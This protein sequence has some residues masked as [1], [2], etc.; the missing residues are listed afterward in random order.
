MSFRL[1]VLS[2]L[3][4]V[5][6]FV[7]CLSSAHVVSMSVPELAAASPDIVVATVEGKQSRWNSQHTL[8][9]TDYTL[10]VEDRL[11]GEAPD[12]ISITV[13]GGTVGRIGDDLCVSVHLEPGARYLLFLG[14]IGRLSLTPVVGAGQGMF[15]E[16]SGGFA[17]R[18]EGSDPVLLKGRPVHFRDLVS[19]MRA[20]V[21]STPLAPRSAGKAD[22]R[23]PAKIWDPSPGRITGSAPP[24]AAPETMAI[25]ALPAD[26]PPIVE[27]VGGAPAS[28]PR[29]PMSKFVYEELA[30][31]PIVVNPLP[32][33]SPFSP[34]DQYAMS[35]WNRYAG[36]MFQVPFSPSPF[37]SYGNGVF[38]IAGFPDSPTLMRQFGF[39]WSEFSQGVLAFT[40]RRTQDGVTIEADVVFN[41]NK[42][43][44]LDDA[45]GMRAGKPYPFKDVSLHELGHVWGLEHPWET[46]HV[47]WD[48]V[49]NYKLK[50]FYVEELF[51]DDTSAVRDA[52]PPGVSLRDG[53]ISSYVTD[54]DGIF[55]NAE[56]IPAR[57]SVPTVKAGGKFSLTSI[58][59]ENVGTVALSDPV[60]EVYLAP[61]TLSFEGAVLLKRA[62]VKGK[63][64]SGATRK[65]SLGALRVPP[66]T[67]AGVYL[68][69]FFLRDPKDV[70]QGNNGAWSSEDVTLEVTGR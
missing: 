25:P 70:Y 52:H 60:V 49:M 48:S 30:E 11:R 44:T 66:K 42:E 5:S 69:A 58:K 39:D 59:V 17:A 45:D 46:Q 4:V 57:P 61:T 21:A 20:V 36:D 26:A 65:V 37:W 3:V 43:W 50:R 67:P 28:A 35:F 62:K 29:R 51:A 32:A 24:L 34:W 18:G 15:R 16:I 12:R 33:D 31:L 22:P 23:L 55:D 54:H 64:P 2:V 14:E 63:V 40:S 7:P 27:I 13:P 53:L 68:L 1:R 6:A 38:D 56:Y 10:R 8:I 19:A 41:P 9:V 47:W